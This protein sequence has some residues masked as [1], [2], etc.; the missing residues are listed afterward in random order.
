MVQDLGGV[1]VP[2]S[3]SCQ[4]ITSVETWED[5]EDFEGEAERKYRRE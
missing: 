3:C 2:Q 5:V 4:V 1:A